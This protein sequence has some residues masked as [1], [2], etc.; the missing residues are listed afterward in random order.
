MPQATGQLAFPPPTPPARWGLIVDEVRL[1]AIASPATAWWFEQ[2]AHL[3][4]RG[5]AR[6]LEICIA[7]AIVEYGPWTRDDAEFAHGHLVE[8]GISPKVLRLREW[9]PELPDCSRSGR[10]KRCGRSH[11]APAPEPPVA[12][13]PA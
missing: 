7:G 3:E 8:K 12:E 1:Y 6:I 4:G 5:A 10:C 13:T 11:R 2:A 9:M